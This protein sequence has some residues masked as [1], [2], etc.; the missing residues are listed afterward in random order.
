MGETEISKYLSFLAQLRNRDWIM[1]SLLY[2]SGLR[3]MECLRLC[4]KDIDF[5][6]KQITVCAG[7]G[8]KDRLTILPEIVIETLKQHLK[9]VKLQHEKDLSE[10][11]GSVEMPYALSKKYQNANKEWSWQ[12]VFPASHRSVDPRSGNRAPPPPG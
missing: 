2:G 6:Y 10:G 11:F 7:E 12:Y 5:D 4:V 1:E 3:L 8:A 9:F